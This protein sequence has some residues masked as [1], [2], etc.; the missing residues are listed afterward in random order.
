VQLER[1]A[2]RLRR[3]T[4]WEAL[5]LGHAMLRAWA[6]P[7]YRAWL[8]TYWVTGLVLLAIFHARQEIALLVLWWLKPLFDRILLFTFSRSLFRAPTPFREVL[9]ALPRL[10]GKTGLLSA[11]TLR[12]FSMARSFLLPVWQLEEQHGKAA[13]ARFQVLSRRIRGNA[14]WLTFVC[15]NLNTVLGFSLIMVVEALRPQG[16]GEAFSFA[17]WF[18]DDLAPGQAFLGS[19]LVMVAESL[20][21]PFYV[22]S[23]FALYLHRRS[24]LE[25]WDME[26]AFRRLADR[27]AP[28]GRTRAAAGLTAAALLAIGLALAPGP[29]EAEATPSPPH[30]ASRPKQTI[31]RILADPVFGQKTEKPTWRWR[32]DKEDSPG[33]APDWMKGLLGFMEF[34]SQ[35]LRALAWIGLVLLAAWLIHL[36][37]LYRERRLGGKAL[38]AAP[39]EF[40][41]GLDLRPDSLPADIPGAARAALAAGQIDKAMGFLY[42]G[43]LAALIHR[44]QV[45]FQPGDTESDCRHRLRGRL[46]AAAGR[47]FDR[48]L[49]AWQ[50]TAY[51][52]RPPPLPELE[53][54]CRDWA[55]FFGPSSPGKSP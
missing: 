39:P 44:Q 12:R 36:V 24:E 53:G 11:L 30:E 14:V 22:A 38:P 17:H 4:P 15:V 29:A 21:E 37:I 55:G 16:M 49:S 54:L 13:R 41:F 50:D 1:I 35:I 31:D 45:E 20:V 40:L 43:A 25:G 6:V 34:S 28:T 19:L 52:R 23:G 18:G 8:G 26:L 51:A 2:V 9:S 10:I 48:L 32:Q 47:Y 33:K 27:G 42:R 7:A 3:R 5:D 46:E